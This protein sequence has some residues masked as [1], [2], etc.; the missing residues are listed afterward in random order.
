KTVQKNAVFCQ[1]KTEK[2]KSETSYYAQNDVIMTGCGELYCANNPLYYIDPDGLWF[3]KIEI[4]GFGVSI[5]DQGVGVKAFGVGADYN[6]TDGSVQF[7]AGIG[8]GAEADLGVI[9]FEAYAG[10]GVNYDPQTGHLWG[11]TGAGL[12]GEAFGLGGYYGASYNTWD[13]RINIG[14]DWGLDVDEAVKDYERL[15]EYFAPPKLDNRLAVFQPLLDEYDNS[16]MGNE[17][18]SREE[19]V[20]RAIE[21]YRDYSGEDTIKNIIRATDMIPGPRPKMP[22][23]WKYLEK[24]KSWFERLWHLK[25]TYDKKRQQTT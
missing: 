22:K 16:Y 19:K 17:D 18:L 10:L 5:G 2:E 3:I 14:G 24:V 25:G 7:S 23:R 20:N 6:W 21:R 9:G 11:D 13:G 12:G 4:F 8:I 15:E 1:L